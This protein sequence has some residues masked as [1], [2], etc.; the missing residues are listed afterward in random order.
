MK[1]SLLRAVLALV[2]LTFIA[3]ACASDTGAQWTYAP[4]T[5]S[6]GTP[7]PGAS[8]ETTTP[9]QSAGIAAATTAPE[10]SQEPGQP[11]AQSPATGGEPRVIELQANAAL[12]FTDPSGQQITDIPVTPGETIVFQIDNVAGFEHNFWIGT[13]SE[14]SAPGATTDVGIPAWT[15]G[16]QTLE[17]VV[18][19]DVSGLKFGCTIPGHYYTMQGT[20]SAS[21]PAQPATSAESPQPSQPAPAESVAPAQLTEPVPAESTAPAAS[22]ASPATTDAS[23]TT[24]EPRVIEL[25][26]TPAL[27]F[28]DPS[29]QQVTDIPVTPGETIVFQ[30]DNVAGFE[31]DF[32]IGTDSELSAP[33]ATTDV[34]IPGWTSGVQTLEWVVPA[35]VSGLKFGCTIPGHYYTMQGTFSVS[36]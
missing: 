30:I 6:S 1:P 18:P 16:V 20:F 5:V 9:E 7:G 32:W 27:Q 19:A 28:T 25:Q 14:L 31:H 17:W 8:S 23:P 22:N 34:G 26:S 10:Q 11:P 2:A 33:G 24:G 13:D 3:A 15:S 36:V 4:V 29:G 21:G 35:D 12:Q